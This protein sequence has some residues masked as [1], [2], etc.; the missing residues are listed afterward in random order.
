MQIGI[1]ELHGKD[2]TESE[3]NFKVSDVLLSKKP[4]D[5]DCERFTGRMI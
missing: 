1:A 5:S 3:E 2:M 4:S